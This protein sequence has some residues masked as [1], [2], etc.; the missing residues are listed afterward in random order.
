MTGIKPV[1][2]IDRATGQKVVESVL[3]DKALRFAYETLLGRTLWS[4]LFGSRRVSD[5]LGRRYDRPES[6]EK[7][8][9]LTSL[10]GCRWEEAEK[11]VEAYETFN[12]FFTRHLKSGARP[13]A[14]AW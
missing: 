10:P 2:Y 13:W 14:K 12:D 9:A 5:W 1:E 3:G 11:P 8:A 7:I 4:V 6:K